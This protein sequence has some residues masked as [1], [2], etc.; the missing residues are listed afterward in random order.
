MKML[1]KLVRLLP[2]KSINYIG[3]IIGGLTWYLVPKKRKQMAKQNIML[4]LDKNEVTAEIIA[5]KSFGLQ[6]YYLQNCIF[7]HYTT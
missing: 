7:V 5:K 6:R 2:Y 3:D 4:A 1:S